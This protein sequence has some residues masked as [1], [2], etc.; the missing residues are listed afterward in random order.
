MVAIQFFSMEEFPIAI[1]KNKERNKISNLTSG[2]K[3]KW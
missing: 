2:K 3:M 1:P